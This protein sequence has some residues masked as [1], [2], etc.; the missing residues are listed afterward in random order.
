[1]PETPKGQERAIRM[2]WMGSE[3]EPP[4]GMSRRE[5]ARNI[6]RS[7]VVGAPDRPKLNGSSMFMEA[8]LKLYRARY[9][10]HTASLIWEAFA[11]LDNDVVRVKFDAAKSVHYLHTD[12]GIPF[13]FRLAISDALRCLRS[14]LDYLVCALA[15]AASITENNVT[16]PFHEKRQNVVD[17]FRPKVKRE[18]Q[19]DMPAGTLHKLGVKYPD[20]KDAVILDIIQPF[21]AADG[22]NAMGD[23]LWRLITMDN[24]DKHRLLSP[25]ITFSHIKNAQIGGPGGITLQDVGIAGFSKDFHAFQVV[26]GRQES[27]PQPDYTVDVIFPEGTRLAGKPVL[28]SFVEGANAVSKVIEIFETIFEGENPSG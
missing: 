4:P 6:S 7:V 10:T 21:S 1:M 2:I 15:R 25:T 14:A 20:L 27:Q 3:V 11:N 26:G 28:S 23:M 17:M 13:D 9:H 8:R 5:G 22:A 12:I 19:K 24:L 18:G 16:F